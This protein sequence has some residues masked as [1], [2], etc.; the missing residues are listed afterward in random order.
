MNFFSKPAFAFSLPRKQ[1][2]HPLVAVA[3]KL[4]SSSTEGGGMG[5]RAV[6]NTTA[7][8]SRKEPPGGMKLVTPKKAFVSF[9]GD[10]CSPK[11]KAESVSVHDNSFV[12]L[13]GTREYLKSP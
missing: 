4:V 2:P 5:C 11:P 6:M 12:W 1:H 10:I 7:L 9:D 13:Q 8:W 3:K